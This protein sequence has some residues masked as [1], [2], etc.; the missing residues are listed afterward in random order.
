[1]LPPQALEEIGRD[2]LRNGHDAGSVGDHD[3][4]GV[5]DNTATADREIDF[6]GTAVERADRGDAARENRKVEFEDVGKI[7]HVA[8]HDESGDATVFGLG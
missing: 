6:T 5:D 1:M 7:A 2:L 8:V 3:V 4:A